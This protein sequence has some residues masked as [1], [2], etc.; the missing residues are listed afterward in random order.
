[1]WLFD[2]RKH[3]LPKEYDVQSYIDAVVHSFRL[4]DEYSYT[5]DIQDY[6]VN[7]TEEEREV[8]RRCMLAISQI[9]VCLKVFRGNINLHI[10]VPEIANV[11]AVF[12]FNERVHLDFYSH[13]IELL[14]LNWEYEKLL[15][16]PIF[17]ERYDWIQEWMKW[18]FVDKLIFFTLFTENTSLFSQF[19]CLMSINK[20]KTYLKG[21]SNGIM[22]ST[23]EEWNHA[24]F[25]A[26]LINTIR[27]EYPEMITKERIEWIRNL[28]E[29]SI[30]I[31]MKI[32][33]WIFEKWDLHYLKKE[34]IKNYIK[35]R[36]QLWM[37]MIWIDYQWEECPECFDWFETELHTTWH[38]DF[39]SKKWIW[40]S[41]RT[42]SVSHED[43]F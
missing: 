28:V 27:K 34:D 24:Q 10:P 31:E 37:K 5:S 30:E 6:K 43:L 35:Y 41:S 33:D 8:S 20:N 4:K 22:A 25:W 11:W 3:I 36:M 18:D 32:V 15:E 9:E 12:G 23:K 39:F 17:K 16:V 7:M 40:Y 29:K 1:M 2:E 42:T 19:L 38:V 13:L 21:M 26:F 14:W